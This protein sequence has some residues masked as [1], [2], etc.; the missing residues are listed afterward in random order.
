MMKN[1]YF[2]LI[3]N[4]NIDVKQASGGHIR[5]PEK[6]SSRLF[7]A[8]FPPQE[9]RR[10]ETDTATRIP[11]AQIR[12]HV[13]KT[14]PDINISVHTVHRLMMPRNKDETISCPVHRAYQG[15]SSPSEKR[16]RMQHADLHFTRCLESY[17]T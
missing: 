3:Q 13:M 16:Q 9:R 12:E 14:H 1:M 17:A 4:K 6:H 10:T 2:H 11:L 15:A 5:I 8:R 7:S